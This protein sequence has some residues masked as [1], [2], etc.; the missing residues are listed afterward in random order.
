M[1]WWS[2]HRSREQAKRWYR[3]IFLAISKLT[4][5]ADCLPVAAEAE[6]LPTGLRE[7]H[8]GLSGRATHRIIVTIVGQEV[9]VMRVRHVAQE[10]LLTDDLN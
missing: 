10:N 4:D 7:L 9:R 8:F 6:L 3:Q 1:E 2:E 5:Q